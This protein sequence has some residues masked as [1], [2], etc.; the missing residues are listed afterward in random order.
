[1]SSP[2]K[3][4]AAQ[5]H[6][7]A[8]RE[9]RQEAAA[10]RRR[11]VNGA[12]VGG[13]MVLLL[14]GLAGIYS[15]GDPAGD[16]SAAATPREDYSGLIPGA[17]FAEGR[18]WTWTLTTNLGDIQIT[19][20]GADA[21]QATVV[22]LDLTAGGF[23]DGTDCS[24]VSTVSPFTVTCGDPT[25]NGTGGPPY[26]FGPIENAPSDDFYPAGSVV[27]V[28]SAD[29]AA[30]MGSQ[31]WIVYEDS[32]IPSDTAGAYTVVGTVVQGLDIVR[33]VAEGGTI[34]GASEGRPAH[35]LIFTKVTTS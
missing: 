29:D 16:S 8:A 30:S 31:F 27:M 10:R 4:T 24:A 33:G 18:D 14:G 12:V 23:F 28:R 1:M 21:P 7:E 17:E 25:G 6:R 15:L 5:R 20:D 13:V 26:R 2:K 19:L 35:S 22:L 32:T 9:A 11:V 34:T 3:P